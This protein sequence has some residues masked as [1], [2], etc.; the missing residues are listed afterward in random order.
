M[1]PKQNLNKMIIGYNDI[2][3]LKYSLVTT[4]DPLIRP[5]Q[6]KANPSYQIRF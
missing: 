1:S 4:V 5:I 2:Y 6:P 3:M